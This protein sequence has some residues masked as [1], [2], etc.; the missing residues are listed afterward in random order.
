MIA[1]RCTVSFVAPG[2]LGSE[3]AE[4]PEPE[5]V[6]FGSGGNSVVYLVFVCFSYFPGAV[7]D[8]HH[9]NL[10][11]YSCKWDSLVPIHIVLLLGMLS[12]W[13]LA[14]LGAPSSWVV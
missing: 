10:L 5:V 11:L 7:F 6:Y 1:S 13:E 8:A 3:C 14:V 9:P 4:S 12:H 2:N